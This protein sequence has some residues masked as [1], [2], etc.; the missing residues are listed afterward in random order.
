MK[1]SLPDDLVTGITAIDQQHEELIRA[2]DYLMDALKQQQDPV[3]AL[4]V[5]AFLLSFVSEHFAAEEQAMVR[6]GYP[7]RL[8]HVAAHHSFYLRLQEVEDE[9]RQW[10]AGD[11]IVTD[12]EFLL[13]DLLTR[14][15][16]GH[17]IPMA[18]YLR[19]HG[20]DFDGAVSEAAP[21]Q[22]PFPLI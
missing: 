17:D 20:I 15:V 18:R 10:G 7:D 12:I 21:K 9:I 6:V 19:A 8:A 3:A 14:H 16:R 11:Q 5:Q 4:R 22:V 2:A 13:P 1:P